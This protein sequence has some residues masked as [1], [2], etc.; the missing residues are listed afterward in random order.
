MPVRDDNVKML[1]TAKP[2]FVS[3][4]QCETITGVSRWT[5]RQ[6]AY[7]GKIGSIKFGTRLLI[8]IS[9]VRRVLA[10]GYRP[11]KEKP[12]RKAAS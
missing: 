9:E 2:E 10:E 1:E 5:W 12:R 8:P 7:E 11:P 4:D 6:Y 3:V